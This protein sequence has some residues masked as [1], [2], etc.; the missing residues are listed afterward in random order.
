MEERWVN[1]ALILPILPNRSRFRPEGRL[2]FLLTFKLPEKEIQERNRQTF[3]ASWHT[4]NQF[5][6]YGIATIIL[7]NFILV[8]F[9]WKRIDAETKTKSRSRKSIVLM[10]GNILVM[11]ARARKTPTRILTSND[12]KYSQRFSAL[13]EGEQIEALTRFMEKFAL[14]LEKRNVLL[15]IIF[16]RMVP[17]NEILLN[18]FLLKPAQTILCN[19]WNSLIDRFFWRAGFKFGEPVRAC[20]RSLDHDPEN[21]SK[22]FNVNLQVSAFFTNPASN[23]K[24]KR[25]IKTLKKHRMPLS[26]EIL[27]RLSWASSSYALDM[28][29]DIHISN[30]GD[31]SVRIRFR[32]DGVL[33]NCRISANIHGAVV[34][35]IKIQSNLQIDEQRIRKMVVCKCLLRIDEKL[36]SCFNAPNH[37]RRESVYASSG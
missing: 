8:L 22:N 7:G 29:L 21:H 37:S 11:T 5:L 36:S 6:Y 27:H 9:Y 25:W 19:L 33:R 1:L 30:R 32:I 17:K 3:N 4:A 26:Q 31:V 16:R 34:S 24:T 15:W 2:P 10:K 20:N 12:Q 28:V 35:R 18:G 14:Q 13:P 23:T